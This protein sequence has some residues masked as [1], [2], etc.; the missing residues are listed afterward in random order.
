MITIPA[1]EKNIPKVAEAVMAPKRP[2]SDLMLEQVAFPGMAEKE[3]NNIDVKVALSMGFKSSF[4]NLNNSS[5][6]K[7]KA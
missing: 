4:A 3:G 2:E 6:A 1:R 5:R 7:M